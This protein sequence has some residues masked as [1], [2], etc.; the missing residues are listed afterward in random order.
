[1]FCALCIEPC[2]TDCIHMGDNHDVSAYTREDMIVDFTE[3]ARQGKQTS[4]PF[5]MQKEN[6]PAWAAEQK[7]RWEERAAPKRELMLKALEATEI[8]KPKKAASA[9]AEQAPPGD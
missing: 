9:E 6:L 3:L 2:P 7:R 1:M 5:W 8:P 4:E